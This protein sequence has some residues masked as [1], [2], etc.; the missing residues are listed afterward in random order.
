MKPICYDM[1][2][3]LDGWGEA[4]LAEGFEVIGYDI[5]DMAKEIG[6]ERMPGL[7]LVL[8]DVLTIHGSELADA[9]CIVASPPCQGLQLP[10]DAVEASEGVTAT[11]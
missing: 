11:R 7:K 8:R 4:F 10:C 2:C 6:R 9:T 3:G 1:F 5:V